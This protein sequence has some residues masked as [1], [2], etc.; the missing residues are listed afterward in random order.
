M[1][2]AHM[3]LYR[4]SQSRSVLMLPVPYTDST[5]HVLQSLRLL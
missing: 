3:S 4:E 5:A 1:F 2:L